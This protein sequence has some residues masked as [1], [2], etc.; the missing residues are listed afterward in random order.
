MQQVLA[1][2]KQ[3]TITA[4]IEKVTCSSYIK[5]LTLLAKVIGANQVNLFALWAQLLSAPNKQKKY[6][7]PV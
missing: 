2:V 5:L 1:P 4:P 3:E 6:A 7:L